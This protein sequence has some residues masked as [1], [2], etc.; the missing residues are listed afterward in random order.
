ME[1]MEGF[2]ISKIFL[3]LCLDGYFGPTFCPFPVRP[4]SL[5]DFPP[6]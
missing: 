4:A 3:D 2:T 5:S 1:E 6:V